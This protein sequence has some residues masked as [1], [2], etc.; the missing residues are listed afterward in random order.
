MTLLTD[1]SPGTPARTHARWRTVLYT[2]AALLT[3]AAMQLFTGS[4]TVALEPFGVKLGPFE[5][6][7]PH[8]IDAWYQGQWA[9]L[10][11]ILP[12]GALLASLRRPAGRPLLVQFFALVMG[13][14]S[15]TFVVVPNPGAIP[16]P[17]W[18]CW[19]P[20]A[21]RWR[22]SWAPTP[23]AARCCAHLLSRTS[24]SPSWSPVSGWRW[25]CSR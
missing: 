11:A 8:F 24:A 10:S 25:P 15:L 13:L 6:D 14:V 19:L 2:V 18:S 12:C 20:G 21:S 5:P 7:V 16:A 1:R 22:S 9:V 17:G 23:P 3:F 4:F